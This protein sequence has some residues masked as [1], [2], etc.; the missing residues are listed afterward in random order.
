MDAEAKKKKELAERVEDAHQLGIEFKK[1]A[2]FSKWYSQVI[3]K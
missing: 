2:N 3:T 1:E